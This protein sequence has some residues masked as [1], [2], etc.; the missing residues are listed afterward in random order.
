MDGHPSA[1]VTSPDLSEEVIL[2]VGEG[3]YLEEV[4]GTKTAAVM[5]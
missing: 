4:A 5:G 3:H 1:L 2:V